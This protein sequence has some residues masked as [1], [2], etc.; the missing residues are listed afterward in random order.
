[1]NIIVIGD[2]HNHIVEAE[3]VASLYDKTHKV[4]F[5]GDYFDDFGDTAYDAINTAKWLKESL[6][7]PNRIHLMGNHDINYSY[8]N[9]VK[10]SNGHLQNIYNCSGY[11]PNKDFAIN[12]VMTESDWDKIKF[13][14]FENGF[15]FSHGGFHPHW[16]EHPVNGMS[17]E[18]IAKCVEVATE[19]YKNREWDSYIGAVGRCRGGIQKVGGILWLDDYREG[20]VISNFKQVFGHTPTMNKIAINYDPDIKK[21]V[22]INVDCG[23]C[24]VLEISE[25]GT[26]D[27]IDT[28]LPNFYLAAAEKKRKDFIKRLDMGAY[29]KIYQ[30]L[31]KK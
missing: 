17:T 23:L 5:V 19:N 28:G 13:A 27:V 26:Y 2:I 11:D 10:D 3:E 21:G 14:H 1:M 9:Y 6:D 12:G 7:K 16:F 15:W 25:D 18:H 20:Q 29:D 30:S 4:I 31:D 22:N 8:L 24:Q